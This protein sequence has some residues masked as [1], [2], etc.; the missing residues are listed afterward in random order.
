MSPVTYL[1]WMAERLFDKAFPRIK[2]TNEGFRPIDPDVS[3]IALGK[4]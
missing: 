2:L 4:A 1:L 3:E